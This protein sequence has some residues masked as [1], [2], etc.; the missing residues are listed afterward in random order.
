MYPDATV[1]ILASTFA[2]RMRCS[3][4]NQSVPASRIEFHRAWCCKHAFEC[5]VNGCRQTHTATDMERHVIACHSSSLLDPSPP[6]TRAA[7]AATAVT[8]VT[9][10]TAVTAVTAATAATYTLLVSRFAPEVVVVVHDVVVVVSVNAFQVGEVPTVGHLN[11]HMRAYYPSPEAPPVTATVSQFRVNDYA[12]DTPLEIF[13]VGIVPPVIASR[14]NMTVTPYIPHITPRCVMAAENVLTPS[15][16]SIYAIH[17]V[18]D[19][20]RYGVRDIPVIMRPTRRA[21]VHGIP[22]AIVR[23]HFERH[24]SH[25][26]VGTV[27]DG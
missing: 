16:A 24:A 3:E 19:L 5:P 23:L 2:L 11:L 6:P 22:V 12:C 25:A 4:C 13:N 9:A 26:C 1:D 15:S 21:E 14:E 8:A 27:Y 18:D 10:A 17:G 7:T 20:H